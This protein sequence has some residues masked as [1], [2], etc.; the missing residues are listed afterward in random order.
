MPTVRLGRFVVTGTDPQI[1]TIRA[2]LAA[3]RYPVADRLPRDIPVGFADLSPY[4]ALG[5][6]WTDG[7]IQVERTLPG[8]E[9]EAVF[10]AEAWHAVDQYL[11]TNADRAALLVAAHGAGPDGHGWFDNASY[12][13][14]LGETM[15][16]VF[17]AAYTLYPPTGIAWEHKVTPGLTAALR[18]ILTPTPPPPTAPPV[19]VPFPAAQV[20]PWLDKSYSWTKAEKT[21]KAA[22][23]GW[24]G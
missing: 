6:F 1:A 18:G 16:D 9:A 20:R 3:C 10:L 11:L 24:L 19:S 5:L 14:D 17:L 4:Q 13:A 22:I 2:A 12:Y 21:A 7:R 15:M 23:R 8:P